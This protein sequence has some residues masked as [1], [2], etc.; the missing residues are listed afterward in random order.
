MNPKVSLTPHSGAAT[1]EAQD[2][3]GAE[4]TKQI[5]NSFKK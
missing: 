4:L 2:R 3:I 5:I 1:Q